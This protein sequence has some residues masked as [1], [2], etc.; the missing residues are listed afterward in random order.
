MS[1]KAWGHSKK[2]FYNAD[3]VEGMEGSEEEEVAELEEK[4]AMM[5][6]K[7]LATGLDQEDFAAVD[8]AVWTSLLRCMYVCIYVYVCVYVCIMYVCLYVCICIMYVCMYVYI[9]MG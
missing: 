1:D 9:Y 5:L 7:R 6:Q 4:E 8:I 3:D 2:V